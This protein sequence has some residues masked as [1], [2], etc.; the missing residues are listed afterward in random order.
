MEL[1]INN[2]N[3]PESFPEKPEVKV[4]VSNDC[5]N[6]YLHYFVK[7]E[8]LRAVTAEDQG[9]VWE[10]SCVE[11]F[12]QVPGDDHYYNFECNCIGAMVASRRLSR[13]EDVRVLPPEEMSQIKRKCS[14]PREVI[15]EKDGLFEWEV[16]LQIPL[17]LIFRGKEPVFPQTL[18][19][20][21]YK[22]GDKTKKPH[23]LSWQP[24]PLPKPDFHCPQF[25]G[26][27]ELL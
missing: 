13:N 24:I 17:R 9:P 2:V 6:L 8:Q 16:E 20:N 26:E 10:D 3:W 5:E 4:I 22:C 18:R 21:F 15:E 14:F 1:L 19:A 23:F 7:G 25:F 12:C 11:F 27:I